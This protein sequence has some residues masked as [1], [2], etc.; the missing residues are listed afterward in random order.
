MQLVKPLQKKTVELSE[1][2]QEETA[3]EGENESSIMHN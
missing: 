2:K 3:S 1:K